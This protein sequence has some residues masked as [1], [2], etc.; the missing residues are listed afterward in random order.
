MKG[1]SVRVVDEHPRQRVLGG[2]VVVPVDP[3]LSGVA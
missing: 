2:R 1:K 3:R